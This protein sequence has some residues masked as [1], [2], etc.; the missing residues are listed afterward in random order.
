MNLPL[1]WE[2]ANVQPPVPRYVAADSVVLAVTLDMER[3]ALAALED[4]NAKIFLHC[5]FKNSELRNFMN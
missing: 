3:Q 4:I 1:C 2:R 5:H